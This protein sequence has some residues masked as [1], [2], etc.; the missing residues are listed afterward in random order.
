[1][2]TLNDL[3]R[4]KAEGRPFSCVTCYDATMGWALQQ[5]GVDTVLIGDSLGM[6]IQGHE[7]TLPVTLDDMVYHTRAVARG[8]RHA[9]ILADMPFMSYSTLGDA[10]HGATRL[11]Q[12]GAHVVK[13]EGG[14]WLADTV[15]TL[16]QGGVPVCVHLGLT[17]QS[18]NVFGGYR[19]QGKTQAAADQLLADCE[20]VVAAGAAVLLLECVPVALAR[21]VQERFEVPVIGIGAGP[22]C[23]G[24]VLVL[25]DLLGLVPGKAAR[26]VHNFLAE[27]GAEGVIG[28]LQRF[29][30]AVV[31]RHY[32]AA[33]HSFDLTIR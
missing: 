26:F 4:Y 14:A 32:P 27:A 13:L 8:N 31:A 10:I 30:E 1:M 17:P 6:V 23:D 12:A 9:L 20:A 29:H 15:R 19:V 18:V 11:M 22:H 24:Q 33:Q 16:T 21:Q 28:A 7:S 25:Y 2:I 5:A 3:R